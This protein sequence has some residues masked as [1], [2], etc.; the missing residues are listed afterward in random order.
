M[1][2][3]KQSDV[4]QKLEQ[5]K[6]RFREKSSVELE[7]LQVV[8]GKIANSTGEAGDVRIVY[9][10]LHRLAGSAGTFGYTALG[11]EA[12]QLEL[13]L[14]PLFEKP[15]DQPAN[16]AG[17][18]IRLTLDSNAVKSRILILSARMGLNPFPS[19]PSVAHE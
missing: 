5:L 14:K 8:A 1:S 16:Q 18:R 12:R 3:T 13:A 17:H 4:A 19:E 10:S 11:D 2:D 7:Q 6:Q 9:Q 15:P